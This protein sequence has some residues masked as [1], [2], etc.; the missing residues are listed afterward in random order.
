MLNI[1]YKFLNT[2]SVTAWMVVIF[3]IKERWTFNDCVPAWVVALVLV[4]S[5]IGSGALSWFL[6]KFL[7]KENIGK[8]RDVEQADSSFLPMY[9][10]YFLVA[11][12]VAD[13]HQLFVAFIFIS[14]F[15]FLVQWQY[16]NVTYLIFGYH[17]YHVTTDA[18]TKVFVICRKE[19]RTPN[20]LKFNN[21]RRINNTTFIERGK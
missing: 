17:C 14:V 2:V 13:M 19:I 16:F 10:G 20:H 8:C 12:S 21:L 4:I 3:V 5:T 6:A 15:L 7:G 1:L 18:G 9:V 11:F